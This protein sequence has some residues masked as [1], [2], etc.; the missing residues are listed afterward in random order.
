MR[1][2]LTVHVLD[3][4]KG[5]SAEGM[6]VTVEKINGSD[7]LE[8]ARALTAKNG[9]TENPLL[10]GEAFSE[11]RYRIQF[12]AGKYFEKDGTTKGRARFVDVITFEWDVPPASED[13][14]GFHLPVVVT[15]FSYSIYR[16]S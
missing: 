7:F 11:G 4:S 8:V 13:P 6:R 9:R 5:E 3:M 14:A 10:S 1:R 15:P 12:Y 16:G 2:A